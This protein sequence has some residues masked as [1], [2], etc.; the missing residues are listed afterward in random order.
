M[1]NIV[2]GADYSIWDDDS[3]TPQHIDFLRAR[4]AGVQFA[5]IKISQSTWLDRDAFLNWGNAEVAQVRRLGYHF[6]T[7][8]ATPKAQAKTFI[9][10]LKEDSGEMEPCLDYECRTG[11][12]SRTTAI[13]QAKIFMEEVEQGL[14]R[15]ASIYTGVG[16][17]KEFGST[18]DY[19]AT[20]KLWFCDI[21]NAIPATPKP[22]IEPWVWQ[23]T[24]QG[25]GPKYGSE[26]LS[27]D[28]NW[29]NG[30]Q[31][32][33]D[34][35]Y[36]LNVNPVPV[37]Q[38]LF[39]LV[40]TAGGL[41]LRVRTGPTIYNS[42]VRYLNPGEEVGVIGLAGSDCWIKLGD[43]YCKYQPSWFVQKG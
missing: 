24:F 34:Q 28:L 9:G 12:P 38:A 35:A 26:A 6:Y 33:F 1:I 43:G 10:A 7:W 41:G 25:D 21:N 13:A 16:Y 40:L 30:T 3:S 20:K 37:S 42:V 36:P 18:A 17:W 29:Y 2:Q 4:L 32:E 5:G 14:G 39:T 27:L 8:D 11:A 31:A 15:S 23:W 22:W 19:W